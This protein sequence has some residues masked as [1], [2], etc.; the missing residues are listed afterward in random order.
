MLKFV[1]NDKN[2]AAA[3]RQQDGNATALEFLSLFASISSTLSYCI[4]NKRI[5]AP[6]MPANAS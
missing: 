4:L 6:L 5:R 2:S 1:S 3:G